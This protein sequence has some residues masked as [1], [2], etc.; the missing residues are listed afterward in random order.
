MVCE[1]NRPT[2]EEVTEEMSTDLSAT[3]LGEVRKRSPFPAV[4]AG[5]TLAIILAVVW[6]PSPA[7]FTQSAPTALAERASASFNKQAV[8][9]WKRLWNKIIQLLEKVW[10]EQ[11]NHPPP[12]R[13]R[14]GLSSSIHIKGGLS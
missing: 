12:D 6:M 1:E 14:Q 2:V 7:H 10:A 9:D 3:P 5:I 11:Q 4:F 8:P 13:R